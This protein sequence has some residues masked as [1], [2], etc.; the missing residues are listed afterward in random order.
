MREAPATLPEGLSDLLKR[1]WLL[2][3]VGNDLR[4][5][6]SF[7][8]LLARELNGRGLPALDGGPAPEN[9][10]GPILRKKPEVLILADAADFFAE[11]GTVRLVR[12]D[13]LAQ[14]SGSTHDPGFGLL[15]AY[16]NEQNP[17]EVHLLACQPR[18][19]D[20]GVEPSPEIRAAVASLAEAIA[21]AS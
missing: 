2:L 12:P 18:T 20:F 6:D 21:E 9:L 1:R 15:V 13:D 11:P 17:V 7:G 5:D 8:P 14:G 19:L 4:G 16:L 3:G 10:T